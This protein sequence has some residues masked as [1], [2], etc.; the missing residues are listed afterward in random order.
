ML[1]ESQRGHGRCSG[2]GAGAAPCCCLVAFRSLTSEGIF[3]LACLAV[4][5]RRRTET[6]YMFNEVK[7]RC[8]VYGSMWWGFY[9]G[10]RERESA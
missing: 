7:E 10:D 9:G 5:V 8:G 2:S 4:E 6:S 1:V 3:L